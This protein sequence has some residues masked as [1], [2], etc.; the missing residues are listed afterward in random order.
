MGGSVSSGRSND[1]LVDNLLEAYH[2]TTPLIERVFR[3]VDRGRYFV[4]DAADTAYKDLA[5]KNG[6]LHISAPCIYSTV[7][8]AL[9]LEPGL[10]FL[11]IGSGTGY[12]STMVG[13]LLGTNGINHGIEIHADV[14]EYAY[15]KLEDFKKFSRAIDEFDF[16]EPKFMQGK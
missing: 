4:T 6:N 7:M 8:E 15:Q 5:W 11:N 2:I 10:S 3:A 16:C 12:L 9:E 14:I 13:L 1:E